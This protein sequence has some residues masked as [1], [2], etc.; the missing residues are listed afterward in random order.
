MKQVNY[1]ID[2]L[3]SCMIAA[4]IALFAIV[5]SFNPSTAR[6]EN[7][8][9]ATEVI[10]TIEQQNQNLCQNPNSNDCQYK[11]C[12]M[13]D[14][15]FPFYRATNYLFWNDF[16]NDDR[17]QEFGNEK[18]KTWILGDLHVDNFGTFDNGNGDV[19]FN[20]ND[21][22]E[23]VIADYQYDIW[24]MAASIV[25]VAR[26]PEMKNFFK[27]QTNQEKI[28]DAFTESYLD[29]I[30]SYRGNNKEVVTNFTLDSFGFDLSE[31]LDKK[32]VAE[33][34]NEIL[35]EDTSPKAREKVFKKARKKRLLKKW[36]N[37][38]EIEKNG[39]Q[40]KIKLFNQDG[41]LEEISEHSEHSV[42]FLEI[43]QAISDYAKLLAKKHNYKPYYFDVKDIAKRLKAGLGSLGTPRYYVLIEG[44]SKKLSDDRILDVKLQSKPTAYDFLGSEWQKEYDHLFGN[45]AERQAIAYKALINDPDPYLGWIELS[46]G[47]YSIRDRSPF[48]AG[49]LTTNEENKEDFLLPLNSEKAFSNMAKLWGKI[50][51]TAH[52]RADKDY[53]PD[54]IPY[55]FE[56]QVDKLTDGHHKEFR[57]LVRQIAF[58]Y[59]DRL[60]AD[61]EAFEAAL[62][63]D[64]CPEVE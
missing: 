17:L 47:F 3:K 44:K 63:P 27:N 56:K 46:D 57:D 61:Y 26:N 37:Y 1:K 45:D 12:K 42:D 24:R 4:L 32:K 43:Q 50:L 38:E 59:A 30:A 62:K 35:D 10:E 13:G 29:T 6:A 25:L 64:K 23:S 39:N 19:V 51:A 55:S 15:A 21:F 49:I 5:W 2:A 58:E 18:T 60:Q 33:Y 36:T 34:I 14:S 20:M 48:K 28:I 31:L 53:D 7:S 8:K 11:Y 52:A 54:L 22:D 16:A 40:E 41:K 9:R